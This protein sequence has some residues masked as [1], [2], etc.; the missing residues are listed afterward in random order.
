M[1]ELRGES[2]AEPVLRATAADRERLAP[3]YP[4]ARFNVIEFLPFE[5]RFELALTSGRIYYVER[6][7]LPVAACHTLAEG[8]G[9][10]MIMGVVTDPGWRKKGLARTAMSRLCGD[11]LKEGLRPR[12]MFESDNAITRSLYESLGFESVARFA[13]IDLIS[14]P[15]TQGVQA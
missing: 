8:T 12:L 7:G 1:R 3:L 5:K 14:H 13:T 4:P 15:V 11:L 9:I 2:S 10:A 6:N